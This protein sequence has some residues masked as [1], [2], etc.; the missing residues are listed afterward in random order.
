MVKALA[1]CLMFL[2]I[3]ALGFGFSAILGIAAA[4]V[5][6]YFGAHVPWYVCSVA[7]FILGA[8]FRGGSS[9]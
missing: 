7:I 5:L 3:L 8:V 1:G 4:W 9:K 6:T 2:F